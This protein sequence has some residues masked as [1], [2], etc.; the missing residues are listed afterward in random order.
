MTGI[1]LQARLDSTRLPGK[2]MLPL[3]GK[4]LVYRVM[5]ALN[6]IPANIRII[7]CP[8]DAFS[9]FK[10]L[11]QEAGFHIFHGPKEDVLER[12]CQV[13]R[14]FSIT[15]IIRATGDNPFVF[16]DAASFIN[17]EAISLNADYAGYSGLPCG[18]GVESVSGSAL[19]HAAEEAASSYEREHVCPYLYN[20]GEKF[21]LHRPLA[22]FHWQG[23]DLR[24][25]IDTQEDYEKAVQLYDMLKNEPCRYDGAVILKN[26]WRL[27]GNETQPCN[28]CSRN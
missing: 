25:T 3:D 15:R 6:H 28:N 2:A 14:Q 23:R 24:L 20:H 9:S 27:S 22:P 7:A 26:K 4:P 13:V 16:T 10:P 12:Y 17:S 5:E 18:A 11:A 19:L 8:E 1:I 21:L